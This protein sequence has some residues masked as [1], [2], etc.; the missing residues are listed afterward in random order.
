[1]PWGEQK[2]SGKPEVWPLLGTQGSSVGG[3]RE[4]PASAV[5]G[6]SDPTRGTF[7]VGRVGP[8][9]SRYHWVFK[10][11]GCCASC[12]AHRQWL[13][14]LWLCRPGRAIWVTGLV[15]PA[16]AGVGMQRGV[17]LSGHRL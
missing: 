10:D 12:G 5:S 14:A 4:G 17:R 1:M 11:C 13:E 9:T 2:P 15:Q 7:W 6:L 16:P 8:N 3:F